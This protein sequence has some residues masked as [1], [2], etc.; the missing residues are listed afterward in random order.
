MGMAERSRTRRI[1]FESVEPRHDQIEHDKVRE[2]V[3][4]S[5]HCMFAR[6]RRFDGVPAAFQTHFEG[7]PDVT[8]IVYHQHAR[9]RHQAS[10]LA[11]FGQD[12]R[13]SSGCGRMGNKM[14]TV[15]SQRRRR[16]GSFPDAPG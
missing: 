8:L 15:V 2:A 14:C 4:K 13:A 1:S 10:P 3:G 9:A 5:R 12:R 7:P 11:E 16:R 6:L